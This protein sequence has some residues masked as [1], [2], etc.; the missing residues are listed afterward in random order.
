MFVNQGTTDWQQVHTSSLREV[1]DL[2]GYKIST[3]QG[4]TERLGNDCYITVINKYKEKA[5]T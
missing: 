4:R 2:D 1:V 5:P 3:R